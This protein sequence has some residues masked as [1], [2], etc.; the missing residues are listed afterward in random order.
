MTIDTGPPIGSG[1]PTIENTQISQDMAQFR[2]ISSDDGGPAKSNRFL[3]QINGPFFLDVKTQDS[4]TFLCE[5]AELPGRGFMSTDVR[6]YGPNFKAPYQTVYEDLNLTFICRDKF[7]ERL[8]FDDWMDYINPVNSY[9]FR[10]KNSYRSQIRLHQFSDFAN[11]ARY[12]FIFENAFPIL[13]NP[14]PATWADDNFHRLTVSFTYTRWYRSGEIGRPLAEG[15][16][17]SFLADGLRKLNIEE[18][19]RNTP[20]F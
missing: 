1:R 7:S 16:T 2:G 15:T 11:E 12:S 10:Y 19:S 20:Y 3:V 13:V 4:L 9:N 5:A 18:T 6:Y 17:A 8:F 14:Q